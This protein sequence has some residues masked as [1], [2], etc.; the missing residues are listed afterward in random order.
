MASE[1]VLVRHGET[2]WSLSGRHTG[3]TDIPLTDKGRKQAQSLLDPLKKW[4]FSLVLVSPLA[5]AQETARLAGIDGKAITE[6]NLREWNYGEYEGRTTANIRKEIPNWTIFT[7]KVF[8]GETADEVGAR[9]DKVIERVD[10]TDGAVALVAHGHILRILGARWMGLP[11]IN[12][13]NLALGTATLSVLGY[14][15]ET[16]VITQWNAPP[17]R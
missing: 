7:G 13:S 15:R 12:G 8:G 14:E 3:S 2:E 16:K 11:A 6:E 4:D 9:A 5:R 1:V 10:A 17:V